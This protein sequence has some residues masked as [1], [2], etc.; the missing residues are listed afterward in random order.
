MNRSI[1]K[2]R[3]HIVIVASLLIA[4]GGCSKQPPAN[5]SNT[6]LSNISLV[7]PAAALA[8]PAERHRRP[9]LED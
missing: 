2:L 1:L 6:N 3:I 9:S 8:N 5:R 7:S 4:A